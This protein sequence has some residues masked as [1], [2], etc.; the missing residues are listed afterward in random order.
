MSI[1][2][3]IMRN[4]SSSPNHISVQSIDKSWVRIMTRAR[5]IANVI[6]VCVGDEMMGQLLPH[7]L[8]QLE[9]CQKSLTGYETIISLFICSVFL[10]G[11]I[12][13]AYHRC[14][15]ESQLKRSVS[16]STFFNYY[17]QRQCDFSRISSHS[18]IQ[19]SLCFC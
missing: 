1:L 11:T 14:F 5:A 6:E 3:L 13:P 18:F 17:F 16:N 19:L 2:V 8:E 10:K 15:K 9:T 4:K 12:V 7:L